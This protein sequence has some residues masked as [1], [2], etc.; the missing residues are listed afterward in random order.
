MEDY[1][2]DLELDKSA[3]RIFVGGEEIGCTLAFHD[4]NNNLLEEKRIYASV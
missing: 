1:I 2:F 3:D 4:S